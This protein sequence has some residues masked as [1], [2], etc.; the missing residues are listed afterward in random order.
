MEVAELRFNKDFEALGARIGAAFA[1]GH[2]PGR[3]AAWIAEAGGARAGSILCVRKNDRTAKL[4][5]LL[6]EP[7]ARGMG[8]GTRLVDKCLAFARERG[9]AEVSLWT[10]DVLETAHRIYERAGFELIESQAHDDFGPTIVG[11]HW[12]R[13]L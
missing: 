7:W 1:A 12:S 5:L 9:Y 3:E 6:V 4:R 11:E 10:Q 2:D 8:V 13:P